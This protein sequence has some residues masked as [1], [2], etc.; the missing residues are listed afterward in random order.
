MIR[1]SVCP[2]ARL[3]PQGE[4]DGELREQRLELV[5]GV[6][7]PRD[8][9]TPDGVLGGAGA[10]PHRPIRMS[11]QPRSI[12]SLANMPLLMVETVDVPNS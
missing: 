8:L 1:R 11:C 4:R 2:R 9:V 12:L 5:A 3:T 10:D 7:V 6:D